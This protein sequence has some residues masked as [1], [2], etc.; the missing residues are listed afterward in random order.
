MNDTH[1]VLFSLTLLGVILLFAVALHRKHDEWN[2][3]VTRVNQLEAE[4][5]RLRGDRAGLQAENSFLVE[6]NGEL[7]TLLQPN[8]K[9]APKKITARRKPKKAVE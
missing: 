6:R 3:A 7:E 1:M 9:P 2:E 4:L 5:R 8:V